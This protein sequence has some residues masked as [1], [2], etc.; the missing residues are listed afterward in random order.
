MRLDRCWEAQYFIRRQTLKKFCISVANTRL[1]VPMNWSQGRIIQSGG[2]HSC[3]WNCQL[4]L[5]TAFRRRKGIEALGEFRCTDCRRLCCYELYTNARHVRV[6]L[7]AGTADLNEIKFS[8]QSQRRNDRCRS[9][10]RCQEPLALHFC[11][12]SRTL[13]WSRNPSSRY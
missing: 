9:S 13:A 4:L 1:P 6:V 7:H 3:L 11:P 10:V 12:I 2:W 8:A 5:R